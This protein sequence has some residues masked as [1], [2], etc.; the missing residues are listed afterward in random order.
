MARIVYEGPD[1]TEEEELDAGR[2][3]D[4]GKVYGI[5][6]RLEDDSYLHVPYVRIYSIT[7]SEDEGQVD[8]EEL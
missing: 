4:S 3:S 2:I 8:Y 5:R 1:G 6:L 7:E